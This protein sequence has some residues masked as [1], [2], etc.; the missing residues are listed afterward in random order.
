MSGSPDSP[1]NVVRE[2]MP[3]KPSRGRATEAVSNALREAILDGALPPTTWLREDEIAAALEMSRTPVRE[4]LRRLADEGLADKTAHHGTV[5]APMSLDDILA[6]YV[7]RE[8][9]E[10]LASRLAAV[11]RDPELAASLREVQKEMEAL[12]ASGDAAALA[13]LNL[14][15]HRLLRE[16][17]GNQYLKRFLGQVEQ[18]VR[19]LSPTTFTYPG[20]TEQACAEHLAIIEAI[21]AGDAD[22]AEAAA[23]S[24]M[25]KARDI[26]FSTMLDNT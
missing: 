17:T 2:Y 24:H 20:R 7:I 14:V 12:A 10:G 3:T 5:V 4:A 6:L 26:R 23:K 18:A 15:F 1:L 21:E 22:A 25:R 8:N 13:K 11:R 19:R 9:L 16:A